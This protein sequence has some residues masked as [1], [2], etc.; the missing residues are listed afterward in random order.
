MERWVHESGA[1]TVEEPMRA[2]SVPGFSIAMVTAASAC[3]LAWD[4]P[5]KPAPAAETSLGGA[6]TS[7]SSAST[8]SSATTAVVSSNETTAVGSSSAAA[9]GASF[10]GGSGV[11]GYDPAGTGGGPT[12]NCDGQVECLDCLQCASETACQ[13]QIAACDANA[14]CA[15]TLDCLNQCGDLDCALGCIADSQAGADLAALAKCTVCD[16]CPARC[17]FVAPFASCN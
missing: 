17:D 8:V 2:V 12:G 10:G 7:V 13:S 1:R 16:E 3:G 14:D 4:P 9:G 11:G 6:S 15:A 5:T